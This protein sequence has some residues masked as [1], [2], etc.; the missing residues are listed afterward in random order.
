MRERGTSEGTIQWSPTDTNTDRGPSPFSFSETTGPNLVLPSNPHPID[1][2]A[3]FLGDDVLG[4]I[5][6]NAITVH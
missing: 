5:K 3:T 2:L 4:D 1:F 6:W